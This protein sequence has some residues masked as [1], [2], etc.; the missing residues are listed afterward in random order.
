MLVISE[1]ELGAVGKDP[2]DLGKE[3]GAEACL[4]AKFASTEVKE[5]ISARING[6]FFSLVLVQNRRF[7][8]RPGVDFEEDCLFRP[9]VLLAGGDLQELW[10]KTDD[11][12]VGVRP[13]SSSVWILFDDFEGEL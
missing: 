13:L 6:L 12:C 4:A 1:R 11:R 2:T 3:P 10:L 7:S 9:I 8:S 5:S